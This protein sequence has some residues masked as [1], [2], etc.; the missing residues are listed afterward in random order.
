[1]LTSRRTGPGSEEDRGMN[2]GGNGSRFDFRLIIIRQFDRLDFGSDDRF[3]PQRLENGE[4]RE[5]GKNDPGQ[6]AGA[7]DED[8]EDK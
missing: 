3:S 8:A 2:C 1:V 4:A 6:D 5:D 7:K